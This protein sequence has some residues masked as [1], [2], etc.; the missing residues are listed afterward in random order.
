[1]GVRTVLELAQQ[2][3]GYVRPTDRRQGASVFG[4][5]AYRGQLRYS[6]LGNRV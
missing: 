3:G 2:K 6:E 5:L 4:P 1:M